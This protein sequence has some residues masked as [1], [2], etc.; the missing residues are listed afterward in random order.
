MAFFAAEFAQQKE[1]EQARRAKKAEKGVK[2]TKKA[3]N[4][5][6]SCHRLPVTDIMFC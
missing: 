1:V 5:P 6:P 4:S 2:K 3:V